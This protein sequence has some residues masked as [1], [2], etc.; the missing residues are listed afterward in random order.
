MGKQL[1]STC[2]IECLVKEKTIPLLLK[3]VSTILS[4]MYNVLHCL[5]LLFHFIIILDYSMLNVLLFPYV[6]QFTNNL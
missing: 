1:K 2:L 5:T 6:L 3:D 4:E